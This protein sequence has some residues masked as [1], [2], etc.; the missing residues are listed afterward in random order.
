MRFR[1]V[2]RTMLMAAGLSM[3]GLLAVGGA[4]AQERVRWKMQ[5]AFPSQLSHLGTSGVRLS[6]MVKRLS[7]GAFELKFFEPGALVPAL[8]CFSAASAGSVEFL[9]DYGRVPHR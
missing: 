5:S 1:Y 3:L 8:E 6:N 4:D 2:R 7:G 9:L